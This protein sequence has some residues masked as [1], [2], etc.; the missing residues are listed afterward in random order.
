MRTEAEIVEYL[1]AEDSFFGF[2]KD[3]IVPYLSYEN[4]KDFLKPEVT[5]EGWD[6]AKLEIKETVVI[7]EM[8]DYMEFAW[9]KVKDHR[10]LSANRSVEKMGAWLFVLGEDELVAMTDDDGAYPQYGAPILAA[11]CKKYD[12]PIPQ[13]S[14]LLN[15]IEGEPC[16]QGGCGCGY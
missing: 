8:R 1:K 12:F 5:Q 16:G 13:S 4:A 14:K 7:E 3:A 2:D 10:G 9:G 6:K 11:I 15:M